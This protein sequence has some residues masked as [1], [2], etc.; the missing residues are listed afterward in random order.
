MAEAHHTKQ[1]LCE[2]AA[3]RPRTSLRTSHGMA[4]R[5]RQRECRGPRGRK[6]PPQAAAQRREY[7]PPGRTKRPC[8]VRGGT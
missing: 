2:L 3:Q 6:G 8:R 1:V 7:R 5:W 4:C